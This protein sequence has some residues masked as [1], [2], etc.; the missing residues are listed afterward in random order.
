MESFLFGVV[1]SKEK[2]KYHHSRYLVDS[3]APLPSTHIDMISRNSRKRHRK[4]SHGERKAQ[5]GPGSGSLFAHSKK[6]H[7]PLAISHSESNFL[8]EPV[9]KPALIHPFQW[10]IQL[11]LL[12]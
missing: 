1:A 5:V 4:T 9:P 8:N 7:T 11:P 10:R 6:H 3:W 2:A 12:N